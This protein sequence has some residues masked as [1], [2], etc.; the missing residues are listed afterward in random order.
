MKSTSLDCVAKGEGFII[1]QRKC[2]VL[3]LL[4]SKKDSR[5][6]KEIPLCNEK[7]N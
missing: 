5:H 6:K 2:Y 7:H 3:L 4:E 1:F